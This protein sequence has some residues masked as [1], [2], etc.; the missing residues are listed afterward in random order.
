VRKA[1]DFPQIKP[2]PKAEHGISTHASSLA[3][4]EQGGSNTRPP[5]FLFLGVT[6]EAC[7]FCALSNRPVDRLAL[8]ARPPA[9]TMARELP[10]VKKVSLA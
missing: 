8:E 3:P 6:R 4:A 10:L 1:N 2:E 7:R 9:N 5:S